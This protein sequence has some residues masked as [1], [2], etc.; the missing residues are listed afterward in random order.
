MHPFQLVA[1]S[2]VRS[3]AWYPAPS[4]VSPRARGWLQNRGSLTQLIQQR[5]SDFRVKQMF[6]SLDKA[7]GD[8]LAVMNLRRNELALVRE[9][10]LYCGNTPGGI[11]AFGGGEERPSRR[12]ARIERPRQP[13]AGNSVI[14]QS[15]HQ[16]HAAQI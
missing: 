16:A 2:P 5:C 13:L 12:V 1:M 10:Y 7:C 14:Y 8:E 11:R 6:Q 3:S 15:H 4:A 9:V